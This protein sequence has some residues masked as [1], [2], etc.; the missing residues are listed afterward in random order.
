M[1]DTLDRALGT[2]ITAHVGRITDE[3]VEYGIARSELA[4]LDHLCYRVEDEQGYER[5]KR[6]LARAAVLRAETDVQGRSIAIFELH[7]HIQSRGWV[8]PYIELPAPKDGSLYPEGL[9]HAEFVVH[10]SLAAFQRRHHDVPFDIKEMHRPINPELSLKNNRAAMKFH[11]VQ[12]GAV[13]NLEQAT[14]PS[15]PIYG[16]HVTI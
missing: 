6:T 9:E 1:I 14:R 5:M 12:L 8:I 15:H 11:T 16:G 2:D 7:E 3:L 4:Q 13:V 10:G